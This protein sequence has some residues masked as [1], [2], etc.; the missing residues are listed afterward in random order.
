MSSRKGKDD[1]V[2]EAVTIGVSD[3]KEFLTRVVSSFMFI[4]I[5]VTLFFV[6][7]YVFAIL[8]CGVY[9]IMAYEI[10]SPK[11]KGHI[12]LR[13]GAA[14]FCFV[15]ISAFVHCLYSCG[16]VGCGFLICTSSLTDI[17]AYM[18]GKIL[19]GPKLCPKISP[20][21]TW[22]GFFGGIILATV[23][24][25]CLQDLLFTTCIR[26]MCLPMKWDNIFIVQILILSAVVGDLLESSFKRRLAVKDMSDM[27]PGHGGMLDRCDSLLM[28]SIIFA[29]ID[30][31]F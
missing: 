6:P 4:P 15:G 11:I 24:Y 27:F 5:V 31:L 29:I 25:L 17:G 23:G 2:S 28:V 18:F 26:G 20:K 12:L 16:A 8:C 22:A 30:A 3:K 19:K 10:F 9:A 21:K 1:M 7:R 14:L 13:I